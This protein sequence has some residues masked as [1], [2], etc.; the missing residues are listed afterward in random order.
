MQSTSARVKRDNPPPE[1]RETNR[2]PRTPAGRERAVGGGQGQPVGQ[3]AG[4]KLPRWFPRARGWHR[5]GP[6]YLIAVAAVLSGALLFTVDGIAGLFGLAAGI[7]LA[8]EVLTR[9]ASLPSGL[10]VISLIDASSVFAGSDR[11]ATMG[12]LYLAAIA[13]P[14][15]RGFGSTLLLTQGL[16]VTHAVTFLTYAQ[17]TQAVIPW[18]QLVLNLMVFNVIAATSR[19]MAVAARR[20]RELEG[21]LDQEI[22]R[23]T[24]LGA[25]L[26]QAEVL[27]RAIMAVRADIRED[28]IWD[29]LITGARELTGASIAE[30][31]VPGRGV[32]SA[33]GG[34]RGQPIPLRE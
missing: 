23:G 12:I 3:G 29:E 31:H 4:R 19:E 5:E 24:V 34:S 10:F 1:P 11:F 7:A 32:R 2:D 6:E 14:R 15:N 33:P 17:V 18:D 25:A 30:I 22:Q 26:H 9:R 27:R 8:A 20:R 16:F 28:Q 13:F 21:V